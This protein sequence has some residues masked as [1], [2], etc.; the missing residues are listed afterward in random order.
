MN[1]E[2]KKT[3]ELGKEELLSPDEI[4]FLEMVHDPI[5]RPALLDLL[6]E[7]GSLS[8]FLEAENGTT[9]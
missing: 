9:L 1:M 3:N 4:R 5:I 6:Q 8:S 7:L 2:P